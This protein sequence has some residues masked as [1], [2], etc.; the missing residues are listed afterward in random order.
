[1]EGDCPIRGIHKSNDMPTN[2]VWI[3][4][5]IA[6]FV[7]GEHLTDFRMQDIELAFLVKYLGRVPDAIA[8]R[9]P[10]EP[11]VLVINLLD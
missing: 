6:E 10:A 8:G 3:D 1:M 4:T 5:E 7:L 2:L 11:P 9:R